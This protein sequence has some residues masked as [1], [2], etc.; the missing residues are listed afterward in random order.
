MR[1]LSLLGALALAVPQVATG[2]APPQIRKPTLYEDLQ[3]FSQV[4]NQIRVNHADSIDQHTLIMAAVEGMVRAADPH[5]YV[6]AVTR[7]Q[8]DKA[9]AYEAG[10]LVPV[11]IAFRY[12]GD[13]PVVASVAPGTRA[14]RLDILRGDQLLAID[15]KPVVAA[16]SEELEITLSGEKNTSVQLTLQRSRSDGTRLTIE[17][18]VRRERVDESNS[19]PASLMLDSLTGYV[20]VTTFANVA[21]ADQVHEAIE[22]LKRRGMKRLVLDLR[23]NGGGIVDKAAEVAGEFLPRGTVVHI[24][25]RR[26]EAK[27]DTARVRRSFWK[28][29]DRYPLV[30][31]VNEGTASASEL[32]AGALQDHDRALIV[33]RPSFGKSLLMQG[34]PL[35]DG[36]MIMLVIGRVRTPCGRIVQREYRS[37][38]RRDYFRL[39][40]AI[41]DTAGRPR[42]AT[43][44]GRTVYGGGGIYPDV[45]LSEPEG[46]PRWLEQVVDRGLPLRWAGG[47]LT[48]GAPIPAPEG[49]RAPPVLPP[50]ALESFRQFARTAGVELPAGDEASTSLG[51]VLLLELAAT[52]GGESGY[53]ATLA[54][55][56]P[57]IAGA[58]RH[59]DSADNLVKAR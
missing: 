4:L 8:A 20:R 58:A 43:A 29:E 36:S 12:V 53:F 49:M 15:G 14:A 2:Q 22:E 7:L 3:M 48:E 27:A 47:Y 52:R 18:V 42:C 6:L 19:V 24:S 40:G 28:Q 37:I 50:A 41:Q 30:V 21:V 23:D 33:G 5:S 54:R 32:V 10:K 45:L 57:V 25:E 51:H 39:A 56:D 46:A 26:K 35:T 1:I 16:G 44:G 31:L 59:F 34:F 13:D 9:R 55:L 11:P 38:S 17:R